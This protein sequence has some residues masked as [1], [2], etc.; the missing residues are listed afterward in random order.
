MYRSKKVYVS[1]WNGAGGW[2]LSASKGLAAFLVAL[3]GEVSLDGIGSEM[4]VGHARLGPYA[5]LQQA[6]PTREGATWLIRPWA[7]GHRLRPPHP[8]VGTL[9]AVST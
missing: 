9:G 4:P 2:W 1:T 6:T 8:L 5:G 3:D 7:L